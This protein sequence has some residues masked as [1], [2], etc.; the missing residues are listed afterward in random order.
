MFE[1]RKQAGSLDKQHAREVLTNKTE[2]RQMY[3]KN[4][5]CNYCTKRYSIHK[6]DTSDVHL[7]NTNN[8]IV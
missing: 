6:N 7:W 4:N 1:Y 3:D 5:V 8:I 2:L